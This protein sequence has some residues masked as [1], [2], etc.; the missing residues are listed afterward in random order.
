M[1]FLKVV[2]SQGQNVSMAAR[3]HLW[4]PVTCVLGPHRCRWGCMRQFHTHTGGS[5]SMAQSDG[6]SF[7]IPPV[8]GHEKKKSN[9]IRDLGEKKEKCLTKMHWKKSCIIRDAVLVVNSHPV[10][11]KIYHFRFWLGCVSQFCASV[12]SG[13]QFKPHCQK[14]V[15]KHQIT[16]RQKPETAEHLSCEVCLW[17]GLRVK[18]I[19]M[20]CKTWWLKTVWL[21]QNKTAFFYFLF[22]K[23]NQGFY[24]LMKK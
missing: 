24:F 6:W 8:G 5:G 15:S 18:S 2:E 14:N 4:L 1:L 9:R 19:W 3:L 12:L 21:D 11:L 7:H 10:W 22:W 13:L 20:F 17:W 23:S 16:V